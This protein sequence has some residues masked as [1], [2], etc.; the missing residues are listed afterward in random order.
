M[1]RYR[2][3]SNLTIAEVWAASARLAAAVEGDWVKRLLS[4]VFDVRK[5]DD[6]PR[7]KWEEFYDTCVAE[8]R[9]VTRLDTPR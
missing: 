5:V 3:D 6:L 9:E 7:H 8:L 1:S 4:E 2:H